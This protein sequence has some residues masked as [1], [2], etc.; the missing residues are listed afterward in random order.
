MIKSVEIRTIVHA[1]EDEDKVRRALSTITS[2]KFKKINARGHYG[3]RIDILFC[4][5]KGEEAQEVFKKIA[6]NIGL[7][8]MLKFLEPPTIR[9]K[10]DKQSAYEGKIELSDEADFISVCVTFSTKN[11]DKIEAELRKMEL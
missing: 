8:N 6:R 3:Q 11:R 5:L 9:I 1:T 7:E 10:I 2:K 4:K